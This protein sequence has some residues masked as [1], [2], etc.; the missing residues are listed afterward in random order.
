MASTSAAA[1]EPGAG[2]DLAALRR[3]VDEALVEFLD[4][5]ER[6]V[7]ALGLPGEV[8]RVLRDFTGGGGKRIR[9]ML[10]AVGWCAGGGDGL[11]GTV[12]RVGAA[13]E[14][15]HVF[16]LIHDDL[17]DRSDTRRGQPTVH[18]ALAAIH[19][20]G[21]QEAASARLGESLAILAGDLALCWSDELLHTA[22]LGPARLAAVLPLVDAMRSELVHG[23]YLDLLT[24]GRPGTDVEAALRIVRY[25]TAKYTVE[26][27]LRIGA[28]L[29]GAGPGVQ[30]ALTAF[31]VPLGEAFQLRDDLL[32]V[33]GAPAA[34][35]KSDL[36]DLCSGKHTVLV[37]FALS[38]ATASQRRM[39]RAL[40][41]DPALVGEGA[42]AIRALLVATGA[43]TAVEDL[44][45]TR[46]AQAL[47]VLD[48]AVLPRAAIR[49]LRELAEATTIRNA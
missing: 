45:R 16:A 17:M 36:D 24:T 31:A 34:T 10:C 40:L 8:G 1:A 37:A 6:H 13:L 5:Q 32:G 18:R 7:A 2:L 27:P 19:G 23:Q 4:R 28:V 46:R 33:F 3:S 30:E 26:W 22:G 42:D 25:K 49:A 38:R 11:P 9:P 48:D 14:M 29:A 21:R 44:I 20:L 15:F 39:L 35:G 12:M 47:T 43:R 41:G